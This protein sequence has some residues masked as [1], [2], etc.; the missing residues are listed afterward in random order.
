M[1][2][3]I[4]LCIAVLFLAAVS[5]VLVHAQFQDPTPDELKM[6]ADPKSP[7]AAAVYLDIQEIDN[8]PMHFQSTYAR[9]KV[10][11]EK[12]KELATVE[13]PYLKS[14]YKITDIKGRTIH[15]DGT[16]IPLSVKPEDL[17]ISKSGGT[18]IA[19]KVFTL[20]SAE[21]GSI[22]EYKYEIRY[23]DDQFTSPMWEIQRPYF[24]HK[25]HYSFTPFKAFQPSGTPDRDTSMYM[26][27]DRGRVINS[28][29]WSGRLPKG[30]TLQTSMNGSY[31]VDVTDIP[32][33]PDEEWMPP[34][35]GFLFRVFFYY[36]AASNRQDFW[37]S[38]GK[39]WSKDVDHFAEPSKAIKDAVAG[40]VTP[41]DSD[42]VKAQ[43]LY[44]AV[45]GLDNT[46]Y[47]R[48]KSESEMKQLKLKVAKHAEDTWAQKSGTS[49]DIAMLY[50]AM[51]RAAG[52]TAYATKIVDRDQ[53]LF[54]M[55][56]LSLDQLDTTLVILTTADG[57]QHILDPGEKMCPFET[58]NWRHSKASGLG[59][60]AQ[61][62][63][64]ATTAEQYY[65]D[66][67]ISRVGNL[68]VDA[69]GGIDG[70]IRIMM[71][72]QEALRWR[73]RA[74]RND[75]PEVKKQFD[76]E[77]EDLVPDGVEAHVDHFLQMNDPGSILMAVVNVK[78]SLGTATAKRLMLPGFF[79]QT[80]GHVPFVK[81]EKRLEPVDMRY[82]DSVSEQITYTLPPGM[83][84][85]GAPQDATIPWPGHAVLAVKSVAEP[86]KI[87]IAQTLSVAF[88]L[89]K[90]EEYQDLRG[91][92]QKVAAAD[93]EE[94]VLTSA[95]VV[96]TGKAN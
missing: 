14:T 2:N 59:Q 15:P 20:P 82:G 36:K 49:E 95:P 75:E 80:R 52:L 71:T 81:E 26:E 39:L 23:D 11:T 76:H 38:E 6:T 85:E 44:A 29:L 58:V 31:S 63:T 69:H 9:I 47:S 67:T 60:G 21:V 33:I 46:D 77:L 55:G 51:L 35:E 61:G 79:F 50:L 18:Q 87:T 65:K 92:Y 88:T 28:L 16:V 83:T 25:A 90:A 30:V 17:L 34:I 53:G 40:L 1:R 72:G 22:L 32:P 8:D 13:I 86:G 54:D 3:F 70:T 57:K 42:I 43:K 56:Y 84:V 74:L 7:G 24:V 64:L 19:R 89:V 91:F 27:D 45:E 66:N 41:S 93:Q 4:G 68:A 12:G 10:L 73:Q 5:P 62:L 48:K 78:G 37:M 94:L 96:A